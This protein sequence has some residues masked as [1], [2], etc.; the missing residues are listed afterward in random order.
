MSV[1]ILFLKLNYCII[2]VLTEATECT[3]LFIQQKKKKNSIKA[4]DCWARSRAVVADGRFIPLPLTPSL[5]YPN[6]FYPI[7]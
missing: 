4:A 7:P 5:S 3:F 6:H 1:N 2:V